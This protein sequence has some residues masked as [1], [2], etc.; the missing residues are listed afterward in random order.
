[1]WSHLD[2]LVVLLDIIELHLLVIISTILSNAA[3]I[4]DIKLFIELSHDK[5][6]D[7]NDISRVVYN[8]PVETLIELEEMVTVDVK[9][10]QV[11]VSHFL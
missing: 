6:K 10:I 11:Q 2:D 1:M 7:R 4:V 8:L 3:N 9:D 5:I